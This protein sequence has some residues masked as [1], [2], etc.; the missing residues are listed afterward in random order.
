MPG[1]AE[2]ILLS[3]EL[4]LWYILLGIPGVAVMTIATLVGLKI[5]H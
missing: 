3:E 2:R 5:T 1:T 4:I